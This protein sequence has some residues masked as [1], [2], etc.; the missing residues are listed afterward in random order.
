MNQ[1]INKIQ[2][3]QESHNHIVLDQ[4]YSDIEE[5][6]FHGG[7]KT[8]EYNMQLQSDGSIDVTDKRTGQGTKIIRVPD[9]FK[10]TAAQANTKDKRTPAYLIG[11]DDTVIAEGSVNDLT[12]LSNRYPYARIVDKY[13]FSK[14]NDIIYKK[15]S[16]L[17]ELAQKFF[18]K[19]YKQ[20]A[21][22]NDQGRLHVITEVGNATDLVNKN[23][24]WKMI[25]LREYNQDLQE[26][27]KNFSN[28]N[29]NMILNNLNSQL[30]TA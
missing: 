4:F 30:R 23:P 10:L 14:L 15:F 17:S 1:L 8:P 26:K 29:K 24:G 25:R 7:L 19:P 11:A 13:D 18:A 6:I 3:A 5:T 28:K 12:N 21:V 22:L 20:F 27:L 9:G 16:N 2:E